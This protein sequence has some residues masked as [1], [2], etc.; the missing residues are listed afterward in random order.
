VDPVVHGLSPLGS[1][2]GLGCIR[3]FGIAGMLDQRARCS[4]P[5]NGK[6]CPGNG[7]LHVLTSSST[8]RANSAAT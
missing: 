7:V 5:G 2:L 8:P 1:F 3:R 6:L 4:W